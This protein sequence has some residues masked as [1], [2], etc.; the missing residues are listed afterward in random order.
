MSWA[1]DSS[2]A[3]TAREVAE[4]CIEIVLEA[5]PDTCDYSVDRVNLK[6]QIVAEIKKEFRL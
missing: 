1:F 5:G 3:D 2:Y 4:K 6:N